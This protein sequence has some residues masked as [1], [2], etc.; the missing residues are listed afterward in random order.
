M[1]TTVCGVIH[2]KN[3]IDINYCIIVRL[4]ATFTPPPPPPSPPPRRSGARVNELAQLQ[5]CYVRLFSV[6]SIT[7]GTYQLPH[8]YL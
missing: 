8:T 2:T 5:S 4:A 6:L 7:P 1:M 3:E